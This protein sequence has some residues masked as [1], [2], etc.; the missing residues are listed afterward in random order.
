MVDVK[1][2]RKRT[3]KPF[4]Q[5][6]KTRMEMLH[7]QKKFVPA[8]ELKEVIRSI[9]NTIKNEE[10]R[11][12]KKYSWL[13]HQDAIGM[14]FLVG[15][16]SVMAG[17]SYAYIAGKLHWLLTIVIVSLATS[18]IHEL[19]HDLIHNL[20]FKKIPLIQHIMF[21]IIWFTKFNVPP[22]IRKTLHLR[23]HVV[24]GQE[25]DIEERLIGLG[26]PLTF[27]RWFRSMNHPI[28]ALQTG[29]HSM[30]D[31]QDASKKDYEKHRFSV[32]GIVSYSIPT[33]VVGA[34]VFQLFLE[35]GRR[36]LGLNFGTYDPCNYLPLWA[37]P[38]VRNLSVCVLIPN[39]WRNMC[40]SLTATYCHYFGDIPEHCVFYQNQ[41]LNHWTLIPLQIFSFNFGETHIIHHYVMDQPFYLRQMIAKKA[42]KALVERGTRVND[43]DIVRRQNY[44]FESQEKVKTY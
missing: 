13:Q 22:W 5:E 35:Y 24:S 37:W 9:R 4:T 40:L 39:Y 6:E 25:E 27:W 19:E 14:L 8:E 15:S 23:H 28:I 38:F 16:V 10:Y 42:I 44:F 20:Y 2:Y 29:R 41:I 31:I 36:F 30:Y 26:Q 3:V 43:L 21:T 1:A 18:I 11:V 34:V 32:F 12:R 7:A 33:V 17:A